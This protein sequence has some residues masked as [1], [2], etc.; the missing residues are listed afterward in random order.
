MSSTPTEDASRETVFVMDFGA[1]YGQLIARRVRELGVYCEIL[2]YD[3]DTDTVL[4]RK[5]KALIFSGGPQSVF[6]EE[7][8]RCARELLDSGIPVLGICYGHQLMT[9]L[10]G[11]VVSPGQRN[12]YGLA[13]LSLCGE[14]PL[15][16]GVDSSAPLPCWMSHGDHVE[17][18]PEGFRVLAKTETTP[19]AA[20]CDEARKLYGVQF[21]PEVRHTPF[22]M[23]LLR[24]FLRDIAGCA[25]SW[26]MA[27]LVESRT[28][29]VARAVGRE[30]VVCAVSGGVDSSVAAALVHRAVGDRLTCVFVDH[31]FL[32]KGEREQ[33]E[34]TFR[35]RLGAPLVV[36]DARERFLHALEGVSDPERKRKIIGH[37]FIDVFEEEA[38]KLGDVR[39]LVQGTLYPDVIESGGR[40]AAT[41]KTHHNVG[42]LPERMNLT[43]VEP[44]RDLF[45]D[46]VRQLGR[47]LGLPDEMV[48]RHP[49][50]GPGLAVRV[51]GAVPREDLDTLREA[52]AIALDEMR[53]A[54]WYARTD[55]AFVVLLP[56]RSVGVVGDGRVYGRTAALRAVTTDDF[57]TAD[58][59]RLPHELLQSIA[60]RIVNEVAGVNR[61]TYDI[62]QKPPGTIEWE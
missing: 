2:P 43:L 50:P 6:A 62:T 5:P 52:D 24:N 42:G 54:G 36:V 3:S 56:V 16:A 26:S 28:A 45:K 35:R 19:T 46:E 11:G 44:L 23:T 21:H 59:A 10:L 58:W 48:G 37:E 20:M 61:V 55:Q 30:R 40:V 32:R 31:G 1:Q 51:L 53:R 57:M 7:A 60:T 18:A 34:E 4:A 29:E 9:Q 15:F 39:F 38:R 47:E 27:G 17:R 14:S 25:D 22:G 49:F 33:V 12:E 13:H 41:I 8:P